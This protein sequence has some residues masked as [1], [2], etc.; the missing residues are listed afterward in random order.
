MAV[1]IILVHKE[2]T[3]LIFFGLRPCYYGGV[4]IT[5]S[6]AGGHGFNN[7]NKSHCHVFFKASSL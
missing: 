4:L 1:I 7:F 5:G 2:L 3:K 6:P